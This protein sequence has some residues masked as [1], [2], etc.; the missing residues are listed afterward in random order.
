MADENA[1]TLAAE[2]LGRDMLD[3][4]MDAV[5]QFPGWDSLTQHQQTVHIDRMS[6]SIQR[7]VRGA[8]D[9]LF[10]GSYP[11]CTAELG[12]VAFG[13][14]IRAKLEIAKTAEA[15]HELADRA[16]QMVI[17]VMATEDQFFERMK[18]VQGAADQRDLFH[19]PSQPLGS[20]GTGTPP[21]PPSE[22]DGL[23]DKLP[24]SEESATVDVVSIPE[25]LTD[26]K[27]FAKLQECGLSAPDGWPSFA[28]T[29][30][31]NARRQEA[32]IWALAFLKL[33]AEQQPTPEPPEFLRRYVPDRSALGGPLPEAGAHPEATASTGPSTDT[34]EQGSPPL[35]S[36][37]DRLHSDLK[38]RGISITLKA[39]KKWNRTQRIA[40]HAWLSGTAEHRPDFIPEPKQTSDGGTP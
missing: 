29:D 5:R 31:G 12:E 20:M 8:F 9:I 30:E 32:Y 3:Q 38:A 27:V 26:E 17:V 34:P 23:D 18:D 13:K 2:T 28:P 10:R 19:D 1:A 11:A 16:G 15:R 4:V 33:S 24:D 40:A 25:E 22:G 39:I 37:D 14:V 6:K 21:A 36:D 35:E 7:I